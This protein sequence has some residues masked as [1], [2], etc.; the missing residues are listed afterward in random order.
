MVWHL[1]ET[2]GGES[3]CTTQDN[4][5]LSNEIADVLNPSPTSY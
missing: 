3:I 4:I 2:F 5:T 1:R